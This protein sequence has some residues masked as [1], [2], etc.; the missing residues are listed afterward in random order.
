MLCGCIS[1]SIASLMSRSIYP[2]LAERRFVSCSIIIWSSSVLCSATADLS[3][4]TSLICLLCPLIRIWKAR[5]LF[6]IQILLHLHEM[7][8][9]PSVLNPKA[10]LTR[11]KKLNISLGGRAILLILCFVMYRCYL[12]VTCRSYILY[13]GI[14]YM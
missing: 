5:P 7:L 11:G 3:V 2:A 14:T 12:T 4:F 8:Y 9:T 1:S 10:S 13:I 6:P